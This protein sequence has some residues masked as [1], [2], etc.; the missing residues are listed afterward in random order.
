[1]IAQRLLEEADDPADDDDDPADDDDDA[2]NENEET[3]KR[4]INWLAAKAP[5]F[6]DDSGVL[7]LQ[8]SK[9]YSAS[10]DEAK[11]REILISLIRREDGISAD[12]PIKAALSELGA[13]YYDTSASDEMIARAITGVLH[14][15]VFLPDSVL[16]RGYS[17]FLNNLLKYERVSVAVSRVDAGGYPTVRAYLNVNGKKD[18]VQELANDF[19][20]GDFTFADNGFGLPVQNVKRILDDTVNFVS[21][22]LVIDGSGSMA[23]NPMENAKKA[24]E[25]CIRNLRPETQELAI[26]MYD[27]SAAILT[28]LTDDTAE[29]RRGAANLV[30]A[31][32]TV[33]SSGLLAGLEA[34]KSAAGTKAII[35]MTDGMDNSPEQMDAAI[36]LAQESNV[37]V[38]TVSTGGGD[39]EYME[40][41]ARQTGG[42]YMEAATDPELVN[43]Y[44]AL[45]NYIV[46]NYCFEYT[47]TEDIESNPRVLSVGLK[48]YEVGGS[49]TY[50]YG[51]LVFA[52]DG[53]Y[54]RR[55]DSGSL[56]LLSAEP[57]AIPAEDAKL[58]VPVLINAVGAADGSK[59]FINGVEVSDV[60]T[61]GGSA[62]AF[63]LSGK[64]QPGPLSLTVRL[65]DGTSRTTDQLIK[66]TGDSARQLVRRTIALGGAGNSLYADIMEQT[67]EYTLKLSGNVVLNGFL[68]ASSAVTIQSEAPIAANGGDLTVLSGDI[69]GS[70]AAYVDF[71][72]DGTENYGLSAFGGKSLKVLDSFAFH[73]DE[74][75]INV[76]NS[77]TTLFLPGFGTVYGD[78]QFDGAEL[79]I[80][81]IGRTPLLELQE[82]LNYAL[83]GLPLKQ[84]AAS[85]AI[86][87]I[88]GYTV[89]NQSAGDANDGIEVYANNMVIT[90][91]KD[92]VSAVGDGA[93]RGHLGLVEIND[94]EFVMDTTDR[95]SMFHISGTAQLNPL[96]DIIGIEGQTPLT[97]TSAGWYPDGITFSTTGFSVNAAGLSEC[98]IQGTRPKALDGAVDVNLSLN[99]ENE[100]YKGQISALLGDILLN[101]DQVELICSS[102]RNE[103][104][105]RVYDSQNPDLYVILKNDGVV[106]PIG[107]LDELTLFGSDL[108]GEISGEVLVNERQMILSLEVDG[109]LD[110]SYYGIRHDGKASLAVKLPRNVRSGSITESVTITYGEK[111]LTYTAALVGNI[112]PKDG[113]YVYKEDTR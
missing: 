51:D 40:Y 93:V 62:V 13:V 9:L 95:V 64:Y 44:T 78:A 92:F 31:G 19:E 72:A 79:T 46:N 82:N 42:I 70:G 109:H 48:D 15:E 21:I 97:I 3:A 58:G 10:G 47:V 86:S 18:G 71:A 63:T 94:G 80:T 81:P 37:A 83:N 91:R 2:E 113:F 105:I 7:D 77:G 99:I 73:F 90:V 102:D 103:R 12:S 26:V 85:P 41:I 53:S 100:P 24:V 104:G 111:T 60:K 56:R 20:T 101:G 39:R 25:A 84:N 67:D 22:A 108:G 5:L 87:T 45:Q 8:R 11:A 107:G 65:P 96:P 4:L 49:R 89:P 1:V 68:Q 35:L 106:I 55:G 75:S 74:M 54:I 43:V 61:A 29:L 36:A 34:L 17:R 28:P 50:G 66:I 14:S 57:A 69:I 23:G 38:Y 59:V 98:F 32:G 6:G 88:T 76:N 52:R 30:A 110:N 16:G 27:V 112:R 33:I